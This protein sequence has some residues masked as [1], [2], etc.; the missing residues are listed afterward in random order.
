MEDRESGISEYY[1]RKTLLTPE[2][3]LSSGFNYYTG[4]LDQLIAWFLVGKNKQYIYHSVNCGR[5]ESC[6]SIF[7][8]ENK[9]KL[10]VV[11]SSLLD[12]T[13]LCSSIMSIIDQ[14][15]P[16]ILVI[17]K[18]MAPSIET[19]IKHYITGQGI[20]IDVIPVDTSEYMV[21]FIENITN[22]DYAH[23]M[24]D[25]PGKCRATHAH[26]SYYV[27]VVIGGFKASDGMVVDFNI[28][29]RIVKDV[30][31][32]FDHKLVVNKKYVVA[33]KDRHVR[34]YY[35][36]VEGIHDYT[37][38]ISEVKILD[39]EPTIENITKYIAEEILKRMP[40]N[41]TSVGVILREGVD[42]G[43]VYIART[44]PL[45]MKKLEEILVK[46]LNT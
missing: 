36:T 22:I 44:K 11:D 4:R 30:V 17:D 2:L 27:D 8:I 43:A 18:S 34:I 40:G 10:L 37:L 5:S 26:S 42:K 7:T 28:V 9:V 33:V 16:N 32:E 12:S 39:E 1:T 21:I 31:N 25:Y 41:V 14:E 19:C 20:L 35:E 46:Y 38:P 29:K 23:F 24:A 13:D 3:L 6:I 15:T 45:W